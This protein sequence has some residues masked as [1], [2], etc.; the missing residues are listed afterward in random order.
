M[1]ELIKSLAEKAGVANTPAFIQ[2]AASPELQALKDFKVDDEVERAFNGNLIS[3]DIAKSHKDVIKHIKG[4]E[5]GKVDEVN[6]NTLKELGLDEETINAVM[7]TGTTDQKVA[8]GL[9][10]LKELNDKSGKTSSSE[11]ERTLAQQISDQENKIKNDAIAWQSKYDKLNSD[12]LEYKETSE[13]RNYI[14]GQDLRDDLSKEDV[15][16]LAQ[17]D[18]RKWVGLKGAKIVLTPN[19]PELRDAENPEVLYLDKEAGKHLKFSEAI[20][21]ILADNKRLKVSDDKSKKVST[22]AAPVNPARNTGYAP[23]DDK[24]AETIKAQMT[25][26]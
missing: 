4:Q 20:P 10:K 7:S 15:F 1:L 3:I 14:F 26:N 18:I 23:Y 21:K 5:L 9:K 22:G 17:Q 11:K 25:T 19:G 2:L 24:L 13:M 12:F 8:A 16:L 6:K